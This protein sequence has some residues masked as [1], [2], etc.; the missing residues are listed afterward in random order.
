MSGIARIKRSSL[1]ASVGCDDW[2]SRE[3]IPKDMDSEVLETEQ[4]FPDNGISGQK[5]SELSVGK[6]TAGS[7]KVAEYLQSTGFVSGSTGWQIK[8]DGT[9]E[10]VGLT[11][12]GGTV[13]YGKT[14][15]SDTTNAGWILDSNGFFVGDAGD[16]KHFK[17]T[18]ATGEVDVKGTISS[19]SVN[20]AVVF[21]TTR[22][23][24]NT[25]NGAQ[26]IR[27]NIMEQDNSTLR[28]ACNDDWLWLYRT[29]ANIYRHKIQDGGF[30][31]FERSDTT[32][33]EALTGYNALRSMWAFNSTYLYCWVTKTV[34]GNNFCLRYTIA[35]GTLTEMTFDAVD[36]PDNDISNVI[37]SDGT[38]LYIA[39]QGTTKVRKF[40]ISGTN[41]TWVSNITM[42]DKVNAPFGCDGTYF[43]FLTSTAGN[44][45]DNTVYKTD[46]TGSQ[47]SKKN[48]GDA[49]GDSKIRAFGLQNGVF[50][51][52]WLC[53]NSVGDDDFN[54]L[55]FI[56][57]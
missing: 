44:T 45:Q 47:Q 3:V 1:L 53:Q 31:P 35:D 24:L 30:F 13:K 16:T 20:N 15:F 55:P 36:D 56:G 11:L 12:S 23:V 43:Y 41:L 18:I 22:T 25:D 2:G 42:P 52:M 49:S 4:Q 5:I 17:Y 33:G 8:G 19:G 54:I 21:G 48:I 46:L 39:D 40:S 29:T 28:F 9:A 27:Q 34:G 10:F 26:A 32:Y 6:L 14:A 57:Y 51:A 37:T 38:Y 50:Q 7:L